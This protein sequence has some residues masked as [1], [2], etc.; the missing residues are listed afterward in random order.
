M[1]AEASLSWQGN[2][3]LFKCQLS[4]DDDRS[5]A[6]LSSLLR[7]GEITDCKLLPRGSND[8]FLLSLRRDGETT[9]AI[10]KP[11]RGETPLY[12]FPDG[13]LYQRECAAYLVSQALRWFLIPPTVIRDGP[14]GV[15]MLQWFVITDTTGDYGTLLKKRF[16]EFKRI[17]AFD[18]LVNNADRKSSHF[19]PGQDGRLWL[20]DHGLTFHV[21]PKLRT[22][23]WE[24]CGQQIPEELLTDLEQL[25]HKLTV[26]NVLTTEL[27][28]LLSPVEVEALVERLRAILKRSIFPDS[29]GSYYRT[30]W[31]AY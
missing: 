16:S 29:F 19:L 28:Q 3:E 11:R 5:L 21:M 23:L 9:M 30:P 6:R 24:F 20:I 25:Y 31:P 18:W 1:S 27:L 4:D 12:D 7:E 2:R 10:Y 17:A 26:D 15:G 8:V 14:F 22:V 13:T